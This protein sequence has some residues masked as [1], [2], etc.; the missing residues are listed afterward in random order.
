[1]K[2][3]AG[4]SLIELLFTLVALLVAFV[5]LGGVCMGNQWYFE[6]SILRELQYEH[7]KVL[8][9]I[10]AERNIFSY[11]VIVVDEDGQRRTY[12]LDSNVLFRYRFY[13]EGTRQFL[14]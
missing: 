5:F 6:D 14:P 9:I 13:P 10:H 7:P 4:F 12:L 11:S 2:K 8:K 1:M 3:Q